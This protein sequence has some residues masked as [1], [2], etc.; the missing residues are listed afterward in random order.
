MANPDENIYIPAVC[1]SSSERSRESTLLLAERTL[2]P[3][4]LG[5]AMLKGRSALGHDDESNEEYLLPGIALKDETDDEFCTIDENGT[6][7]GCLSFNT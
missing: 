3:P 1:L 7:V 5:D 2:L 4:F 6:D